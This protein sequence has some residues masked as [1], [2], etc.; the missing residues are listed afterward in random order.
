[1]FYFMASK[2]QEAPGRKLLSVGGQHERW[3]VGSTHAEVLSVNC[4]RLRPQDSI[5]SSGNS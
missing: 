3:A 2:V 1:M 5:C 4:A